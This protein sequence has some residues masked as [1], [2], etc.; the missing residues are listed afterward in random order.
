MYTLFELWVQNKWVPVIKQKLL[1]LYLNFQ[2]LFK[3]L[4]IILIIFHSE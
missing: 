4:R 1:D 3:F 2:K